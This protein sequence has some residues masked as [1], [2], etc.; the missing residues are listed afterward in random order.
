MSDIADIKKIFV[1]R[2]YQTLPPPCSKEIMQ[3]TEAA[4]R[5]YSKGDRK[6]QSHAKRKINLS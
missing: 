3:H 4:G 5:K 6:L 1:E 2:K